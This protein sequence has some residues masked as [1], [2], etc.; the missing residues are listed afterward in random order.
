MASDAAMKNLTTKGVGVI[1]RCAQPLT[2]E[3]END[4][5][6]KGILSIY[7][8]EGLYFGMPASALVSEEEMNIAT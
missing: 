6:K 7:T 2:A 3:Q 5:W 8:S 4:L 1:K